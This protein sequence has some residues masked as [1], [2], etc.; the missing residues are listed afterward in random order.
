MLLRTRN[1]DYT[2]IKHLNAIRFNLQLNWSITKF[3]LLTH[4]ITNMIV[5]HNSIATHYFTLYIVGHQS[6]NASNTTFLITTILSVMYC[7]TR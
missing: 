1:S 3:S 6:L 4:F 5:I 7:Y 2:P